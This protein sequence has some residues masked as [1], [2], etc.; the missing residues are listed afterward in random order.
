MVRSLYSRPPPSRLEGAKA[1]SRSTAVA[2]AAALNHAAP[3][4]CGERQRRRSGEPPTV[5]AITWDAF[6]TWGLRQTGALGWM[7]AEGQ[8][9]Q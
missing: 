6:G 3:H 7:T 5:D 2:D 4:A 8:S 1:V 9:H